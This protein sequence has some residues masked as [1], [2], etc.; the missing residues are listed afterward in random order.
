MGTGAKALSG[1][2]GQSPGRGLGG[3][4]RRPQKVKDCSSVGMAATPMLIRQILLTPSS[5]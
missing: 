5:P 3:G 1:V 4:L 2:L